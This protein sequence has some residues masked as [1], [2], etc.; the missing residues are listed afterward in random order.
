MGQGYPKSGG[1]A[2]ATQAGE[3]RSPVGDR[4]EEIA[5]E[6]TQRPLAEM[7]ELDLEVDEFLQ[8]V[9]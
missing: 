1:E 5:R 7:L 4:L 6:G 8:R 9:R 2:R 3:A